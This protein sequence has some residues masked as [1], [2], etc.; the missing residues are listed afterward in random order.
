MVD[1]DSARKADAILRDSLHNVSANYMKNS[2]IFDEVRGRIIYVGCG[3]DLSS[4]FLFDGA[5]VYIHQDLLDPDLPPALKLFERHGIISHLD[6]VQCA[7]FRRE[8]LFRYKGKKRK[9]VE[10][11]GSDRS[12]GNEGDIAFNIPE[13]A[14]YNLNAI[15]F[16]GMPYPESIRVMQ[17]NLLPF[18]QIGGVFEG[19]YPYGNG[20]FEGAP[21]YELGLWRHGGISGGTFIK[22]RNL[23]SEEIQSTIGYTVNDYVAFLMD[24]MDHGYSVHESVIK[25]AKN[26]RKREQ[27]S[28]QVVFH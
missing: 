24:L 3:Y 16:F 27:K 25:R 21:P 15:Y 8:S 13:D 22:E 19:P 12:Y 7:D 23:T 10:I 4:L 20:E 26:I 14:K 28:L 6:V 9:M 17:T 11:Y 1:I 2:K 18:L 5:D